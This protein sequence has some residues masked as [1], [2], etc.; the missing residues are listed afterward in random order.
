[1]RRDAVSLGEIFFFRV[2]KKVTGS[3][4]VG[5]LTPI[6]TVSHPTP[7]Q[8][9]VTTERIAYLTWLLHLYIVGFN[10]SRMYM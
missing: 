3:C 7:Q 9:S 2:V 1:V 10:P 8:H 4:G 6:Y 5:K